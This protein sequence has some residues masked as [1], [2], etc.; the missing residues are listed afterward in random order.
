MSIYGANISM[1]LKNLNKLITEALAIEVEEAKRAGK[2]RYM[3]RALV[4]AT[5]PH[6]K[7]DGNEFERV[8]GAFRLTMLA[9][10]RIGL[11]YGSIPRL[12]IAWISTEAVKTKNRELILGNTLSD[13]MMELGLI[14]TGGRWGTITTLKEQI[15]RLFSAAISCTYDDGKNWAIKNVQPISES[16]LWW[17]PKNPNQT[18]LFESTLILGEEFFKEITENPIPIHLD[19]LKALKRSPLALDIY[20]WLTY[21]MSY[22]EKETVIPW[23]VLQIQFGSDYATDQQGTRNFKKAFLRELRKVALFYESANIEDTSPGLRLKPGKTHIK[24]L[25]TLC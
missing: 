18:S 9:P 2:L 11:P 5:M 21:R 16:N 22:L 7:V 10:S 15:K 1:N 3:A 17:D 23:P 12:L 24:K 25:I 8:N 14:P 19:V 20:C 6:S 4:Q 13:F